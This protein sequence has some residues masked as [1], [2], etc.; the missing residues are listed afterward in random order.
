MRRGAAIGVALAALSCGGARA[1]P[2]KPVDVA[3]AR[4]SV[5][6]AP[7]APTAV[8][9]PGVD[10]TSFTPRESRELEELLNELPAPCE[11]E[12]SSLLSCASHRPGRCAKCSRAVQL[13][14][15]LVRDGTPRAKVLEVYE[16][17][18]GAARVVSIPVDG[19][20]TLGPEDAEV[21]IVSFADFE[22]PYCRMFAPILARVVQADAPHVRVAYKVR[23]LGHPH[24]ELAARAALAARE[25][26]HF[27]E[28]H[29]QI[30]DHQMALEER[31]LLRYARTIGLDP[32][33]LKA[34]M[35]SKTVLA[36]IER[37]S[38]LADMHKVHGTPTVYV[39]GR[40]TDVGREGVEPSAELEEWVGE[41]LGDGP[42]KEVP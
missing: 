30:F 19:S 7:P 28:M 12:P 17:H 4:P 23:L 33:R 22:C 16:R 14:R 1:A 6:A 11:A 10:T 21:T 34:D 32:V 20:P 35:S 13:V 42:R 29:D 31:D 15:R 18:Y 24:G 41:A 37:D 39:N 38:A 2:P 40:L 3:V 25:Q 36:Q 9:I 8:A 26:G 5:A 27:W